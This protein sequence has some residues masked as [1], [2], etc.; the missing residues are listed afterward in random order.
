M[1]AAASPISPRCLPRSIPYRLD[2]PAGHRDGEWLAQ[3]MNK[4]LGTTR[5]IHWRGLHYVLVSGKLR[6]VKPNGE[7]YANTDDDWL[8]MSETAG[9]AA[10]MARLY[11]VRAHHRQPQRRADHP[12][13]RQGYARGVRLDRS[14][15]HHSRRRRHR[16][17]GDRIGVRAKASLS[18]RDLR[19]EG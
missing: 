2:T 14:R 18:L 17:A 12:P 19:R 6:V 10:T 8:W 3:H 1:P 11:P 13:S 9:K 7:V 16:A 4:A 15:R 5:H